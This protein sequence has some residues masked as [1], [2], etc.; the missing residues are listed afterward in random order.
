[1]ITKYSYGDKNKEN[2]IGRA[3]GRHSGK[4]NAYR[5]LMGKSGGKKTLRGP[6]NRQKDNNVTRKA[7]IGL[8]WLNRRTS[9]GLF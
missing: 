9:Y 2:E 5:V 1:V 7:C 6:R 8:I 3:C 4:I